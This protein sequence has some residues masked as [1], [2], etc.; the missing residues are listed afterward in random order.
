M[1]DLYAVMG[2]PIQH[3]KSPQIHTQ[4]AAQ[5]SQDMLYRAMLVPL[6]GFENAVHDF[7]KVGA[8]S[9]VGKG[10]NITVPFKEQAFEV[11]DTLTLRAQTAQAVNTLILQEDG[12]ILGDN[13]DGA[14]LVGDL[15][16]NHKVPLQGRRIL[17]IGAGGAVRG[18]LQPFLH[19]QP[20]SITVV[21]R[22]FKKAQALA[23]NFSEF[24]N[25]SACEFAQLNAPFDVI[26]NGTSASLSGELPPIPSSVIA[27]HTVVYDMMYGQELTP[28]LQWSQKN[29]AAKVL[30]GLGMLVGQAAVSFELW[31]NA[32]PDSQAVLLKMR[33]QLNL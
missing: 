24:G 2:N 10:L 20:E 31:R 21:N 5:T 28:F 16:A 15:V 17:V 30:D 29:G 33:Q 6:A 23:D 4:F 9:E 1:T 7:F 25:I 19:E 14:G 32:Q 3:S 13:T 11:A 26:I 18:I 22:T 12:S 27:A 8:N